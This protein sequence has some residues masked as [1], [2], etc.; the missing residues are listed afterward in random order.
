MRTTNQLEMTTVSG[1]LSI[2]QAD[3]IMYDLRHG[4]GAYV[5]ALKELAKEKGIAWK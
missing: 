3:P 1:G 2:V 4:E 5:A